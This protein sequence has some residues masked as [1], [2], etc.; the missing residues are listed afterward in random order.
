LSSAKSSMLFSCRNGLLHARSICSAR[1]S[2]PRLQK[3]AR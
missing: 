3:R 2:V 1:V